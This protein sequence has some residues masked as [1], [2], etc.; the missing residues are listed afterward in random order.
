MEYTKDGISQIIVK[1][2]NQ[3]P[4]IFYRNNYNMSLAESK[5]T[6]IT[7]LDKDIRTGI[8]NKYNIMYDNQTYSYS[9]QT[10]SLDEGKYTKLSYQRTLASECAGEKGNALDIPASQESICEE[11]GLLNGNKRGITLK[12]TATKSKD[13]Y[14]QKIV[15]TEPSKNKNVEFNFLN[16]RLAEFIEHSRGRHLTFDAMGVWRFPDGKQVSKQVKEDI[17]NS[18]REVMRN[19][20]KNNFTKVFTLEDFKTT[21]DELQN[22][23]PESLR[24]RDNPRLTQMAESI[25]P[26]LYSELIESAK[27]GK[28]NEVRGK[29][30]FTI[31]SDDREY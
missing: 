7:I 16:G 18:Y 25:S 10:S 17:E 31:L 15:F 29:V 30:I 19:M 22:I 2:T 27:Q 20:K 12:N 23:I 6:G 26:E 11:I 8:S 1:K 21:A 5:D 13:G 9:E 3:D 24:D 14:A 28:H 4:Y